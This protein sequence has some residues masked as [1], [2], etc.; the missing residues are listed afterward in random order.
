MCRFVFSMIVLALVLLPLV[1]MA[2]VTIPAEIAE[3]SLLAALLTQFPEAVATIVALAVPFF[4]TIINMFASE[5]TWYG[6]IAKYASGAWG[7]RGGN[8]PESQ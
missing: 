5:K 7:P 2:Q 6:F 3:G 4:A 1:A 8:D